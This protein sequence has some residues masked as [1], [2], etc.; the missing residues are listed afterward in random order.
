MVKNDQIA[1]QF[2]R[3]AKNVPIYEQIN[4]NINDRGRNAAKGNDNET[5]K[6]T[7]HRRHDPMTNSMS[8]MDPKF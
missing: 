5:H 1:N 4:E 6:V 3:M 2:N 8:P 7:L